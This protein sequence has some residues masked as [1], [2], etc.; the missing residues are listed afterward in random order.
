M[1]RAVCKV[2]KCSLCPLM[3]MVTAFILCNL[4]VSVPRVQRWSQH[5][6]GGVVTNLGGLSVPFV[7][8]QMGSGNKSG[9]AEEVKDGLLSFLTL[10]YE[11]KTGENHVEHSYSMS[12][13]R[14]YCLMCVG[15]F[16]S[17]AQQTEWSHSRHCPAGRTGELQLGNILPDGSRNP[18]RDPAAITVKKSCWPWFQPVC[19]CP[20]AVQ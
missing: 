12:L 8:S 6:A 20:P 16:L 18:G 1:F 9:A 14:Y 3:Q 2:E 15:G 17:E 4:C 7:T 13:G 19:R 11:Q 10:I 5:L